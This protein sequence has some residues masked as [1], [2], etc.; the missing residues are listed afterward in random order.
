MDNRP[1]ELFSF[2]QRESKSKGDHVN[3]AFERIKPHC[4]KASSGSLALSPAHTVPPESVAKAL[5]LAFNA[6]ITA[7]AVV[8]GYGA[9]SPS[10]LDIEEARRIR[11]GLKIGEGL[12]DRLARAHDYALKEV[13]AES[14]RRE[15][16]QLMNQTFGDS[17]W[18]AFLNTFQE[19]SWLRAM[20]AAMFD[21][22]WYGL[23]Y[24]LGFVVAGRQERADRLR[25]LVVML[26]GVL[27]LCERGDGSGEWI[28]VAR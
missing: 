9:A 16:R 8:S 23:F 26:N 22:L 13:L 14:V 5:G 12:A 11:S 19:A 7:V 28:I 24:Y 3:T 4:A 6:N 20:R 1:Y 18:D 21:G 27:P 15:L 17:L 25:P 10:G 2:V